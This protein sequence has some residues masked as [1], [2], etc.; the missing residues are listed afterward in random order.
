MPKSVVPLLFLLLFIQQPQNRLVFAQSLR[1]VH[2]GFP[3]AWDG[4]KFP[5]IYCPS[6]NIPKW[7]SDRSIS[8]GERLKIAKVRGHLSADFS[9][10]VV[11]SARYYPSRPYRIWE[12]Y[13][14]NMSKA[15]VPWA[16]WSHYN[17]SAMARW[18]QVPPNP[19]AARFH[20]NLDFWRIGRRIIAGTEA[21]YWVG[22]EFDIQTLSNFRMASF[23]EENDIFGGSARPSLIPISMAMHE[24]ADSAGPDGLLW[25]T[26]SAMNFDEERFFQAK[27]NGLFTI[28]PNGVRKVVGMYDYGMWDAKACSKEDEYIGDKSRL[29]GYMHSI[30]STE[31]FIILPITSLVTNPCK[32]KEPPRTESAGPHIQ[33][34]GL[35]GMDFYDMVPMRFLVFDKRTNSWVTQKPLEVFPSMFV[36]HQLNAFEDLEGN[37]VADMV[38]YDSHDPY[39][40]YFYTDFLRSQLYPNTARILRFTLDLRTFRVMY[41]YLIPQ[42]MI[43]ADFP[44]VNHAFDSRPYQ[45]AYLVENPFAGGNKIIK[46]NVNEPSGAKNLRFVPDELQLVMHEPYFQQRPGATREDDGVLLVRGLELEE[47][48]GKNFN[49]VLLIIDAVTME[50][51]GRAFVPISIPFGFHNRFFSSEQLGLTSEASSEKTKNGHKKKK[52]SSRPPPPTMHRT[53]WERLMNNNGTS[54]VSP[55]RAVSWQPIQPS[56]VVDHNQQQE[57]RED[58][59]RVDRLVPGAIPLLPDPTPLPWWPTR[60]VRPTPPPLFSFSPP[61]STLPYHTV[62]PSGPPPTVVQPLPFAPPPQSSEFLPE[63]KVSEVRRPLHARKTSAPMTVRQLY[64]RTLRALCRW[65]SKVFTSISYQGCVHSGQRAIRWMSPTAQRMVQQHAPAANTDAELL[66]LVDA[67]QHGESSAA[68]DDGNLRPKLLVPDATRTPWYAAPS[69]RRRTESDDNEDEGEEDEG[70]QKR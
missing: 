20:P 21:P 11:F 45:W 44:Q 63:A 19:D 16:G 23:V 17:L 36:T 18:E 28:D 50:E 9:P 38:V 3:E 69:G 5:E 4:D 57:S 6:K 55:I 46:I 54:T 1:N 64:E 14:R 68:V 48:K 26:F 7:L 47:N 52:T 49:S 66:E 15:S 25:G 51:I 53:F 39:V 40:K 61:P 8:A 67:E 34:G 33:E 60:P 29:P 65:I 24:R 37:I 27:L 31:H 22:Y 58:Q 56:E 35:W 13:D 10:Q 62:R 70:G 43:S 30:S 42:E 59:Q 41:S 12:F 32:F 2:L